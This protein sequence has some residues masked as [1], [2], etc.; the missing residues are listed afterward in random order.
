LKIG[1]LATGSDGMVR[2]WLC[3]AP[4]MG[5][6]SVRLGSLPAVLERAPAGDRWR[7]SLRILAP[8]EI[9]TALTADLVIRFCDGTRFR[10]I[11][12]FKAMDS[13]ISNTR[14]DTSGSNGSN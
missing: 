4:S 12:P 13:T 5:V 10:V 1:V 11:S 14:R 7:L 6:R 3:D 8:P 2:V 9:R